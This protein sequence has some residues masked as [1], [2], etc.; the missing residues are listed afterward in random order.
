MED[1]AGVALDDAALQRVM[2]QLDAVTVERRVTS[3]VL[4]GS[5]LLW[6][7]EKA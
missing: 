4:V 7:L 3:P 6:T 2:A 1:E 5:A